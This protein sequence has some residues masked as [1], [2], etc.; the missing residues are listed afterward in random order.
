MVRAQQRLACRIMVDPVG[1]P[2]SMLRRGRSPGDA[3]PAALE[4]AMVAALERIAP[5]D[6][7]LEMPTLIRIEAW[8]GSARP[9]GADQWT[10]TGRGSVATAKRC[11]SSS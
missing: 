3:V 1:P 10:V 8:S 5:L 4:R 11:R 2:G 9:C 7:M 6:A